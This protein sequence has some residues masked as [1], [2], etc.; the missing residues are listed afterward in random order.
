MPG[1]PSDDRGTG[2][3]EPAAAPASWILN[4]TD[5][6]FERDVFERS[7]TV[8]VVVDFWAAWCGPCR[9]L[10]P[11]LE[12]L[13]NEGQGRF[14]LVKA[15]TDETP[16]AAGQFNVSGIPAVYAVI[17]GQVVDYF[18][19]ALPEPH[20]REWLARVEQAGALLAVRQLELSAPAA[21]A[22]QYREL[23][24]AAPENLELKLGLARSLWAQQQF[25]ECAR[26]VQELEDRGYLDH[27]GQKLKAALDLHRRPH[28]DVPARRAAAA[29]D[30]QN[31]TL[32][33][34]LAEG[35]A[36]AEQYDE[37]LELLL[38]LFQRDKHGIGPQAK[39][40]MVK[41]F[42]VLPADSELAATYRRKLSMAMY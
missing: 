40:L 29:A 39:D 4:T 30:P 22:D 32:Q 38:S 41:I 26:L 36:G 14:V 2:A 15:N 42:Q 19:G 18:A 27:E 28:G 10:G 21:A 24:S 12:K 13:A 6:T 8:P 1:T 7:R 17:D 5:A 23:L 33:F 16:S 11:V 3:P 37:A 9:A 20:V 35:L 34:Q 25:D 31:L